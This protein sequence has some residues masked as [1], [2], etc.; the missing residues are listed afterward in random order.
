MLAFPHPSGTWN[1]LVIPPVFNSVLI[2]RSRG[3]PHEVTQV[4][5]EAEGLWRYTV[6]TFFLAAD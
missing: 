5:P 4:Q 3:A 6:T 1:E 2:F